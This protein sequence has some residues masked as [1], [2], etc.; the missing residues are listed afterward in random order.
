[1]DRRIKLFLIVAA[2]IVQVSFAF[3]KSVLSRPVTGKCKNRPRE[4]TINGRNYF[5]SDNYG[6]TSNRNV[7]WVE[8]RNFCRQFC[9]DT[10]SIE[11]Q[12]EWDMINKLL[13]DQLVSYIWTSGHVCD[14]PECLNDESFKPRK[15]NGFYWTLNN[16]KIPPTDKNPPGWTLNPWSQTGHI[17]Q[18]QPDNAEEAI[19]GK[20][21]SCVAVLHNVYDDGIKMHDVACYHRKTFICEDSDDLLKLV[22]VQ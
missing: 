2:S 1:M 12:E 15:I 8:A 6:P 20:P 10:V 22:N 14:D 13:H 19:T 17:G 21:E 9:M 4:F 7:S 16:E 5:Y 3:D 18:T 11:T